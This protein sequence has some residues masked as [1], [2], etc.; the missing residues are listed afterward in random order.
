[1]YNDDAHKESKVRNQ[2]CPY[3][4][5]E[6]GFNCGTTKQVSCAKQW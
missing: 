1:M 2:N 3:N 4:V 6:K 5:S